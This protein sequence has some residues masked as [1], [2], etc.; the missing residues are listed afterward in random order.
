MPSMFPHLS[1]MDQAVQPPG[2]APIAPTTRPPAG[3]TAPGRRLDPDRVAV[4]CGVALLATAVVLST[5]KSRATGDIDW[6]NYAMGLIST[7][8]LLGVAVAGWVLV[9]DR[10]RSNDLVAWPGAFG[11]VA[12]GLMIAVALDNSAATAYVV[13]LAVVALSVTGYFLVRRDA[14]VVT[15]IV[16]LFVVYVKL[17]DVIVNVGDGGDNLPTVISGALLV[18]TVLVTAAGW[19]LPSRVVSGVVVGV[20]A[21]LGNVVLLAGL[22][23][24]VSF[25]AAFF[26]GSARPKRFDKYDND[27]WFILVFALL[28]IVGWACCAYLTDHVGFRLLIVAMAVGVVPF[29]TVVLAIQHPTWWEVVLGV[30]GGLILVA[31]GLRALGR[32]KGRPQVEPLAG[33]G[34]GEPAGS[35]PIA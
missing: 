17:F 23:L 25:Q 15:A 1:V 10:D 9:R 5:F 7:V 20:V 29:A 16:G 32:S 24:A 22:G 19:L 27:V 12:A 6:S 28:L 30:A 8:G 21:V 14:F 35:P 11:A 34:P 4:S 31:V 26:G 3:P 18:F 2:N 33:H 13:G